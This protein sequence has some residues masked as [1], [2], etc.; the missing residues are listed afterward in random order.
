MKSLGR[1]AGLV[2]LGVAALSFGSASILIRLAGN[3]NPVT[4]TFLR[5]SV[6]WLAVLA[7]ALGS[8]TLRQVPR[9]PQIA[10]MFASGTVLTVHFVAF[11]YAIQTTTVASASFLVNTAPI[12]VAVLTAVFLKERPSLLESSG[13]LLAGSGVAAVFASDPQ[14]FFSTS[15]SGEL[16]ALLAAFLMASYTL[17]GRRLRVEGVSAA[18]YVT[19]VYG[20]A[21]VVA[22]VV[23]LATGYASSEASLREQ[24]TV[25]AVIGLGLIPTV[26]GHGLYNYALGLARALPVSLFAMLE[27]VV[28]SGAAFL[29]FA[30]VPTIG[31][32]AGYGL[33]TLGVA[34]S[35]R[36]MLPTNK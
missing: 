21:A 30:E 17:F 29:L 12:F 8:G 4:L 31:R 18:T 28:A 10:V 11:I 6:A 23:L 9:Y 2:A 3:L 5:L 1:Y 15:G 34:F 26:L 14:G 32:I 16:S 22:L 35:G 13:V 7:L 19:Y 20:F 25:L 36:S 33:I 24:G 27:P